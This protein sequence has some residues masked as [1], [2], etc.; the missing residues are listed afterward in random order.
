MAPQ[1]SRLAVGPARSVQPTGAALALLLAAAYAGVAIAGSLVALLS[2][3]QD[4]PV[5]PAA[6]VALAALLM[7]GLRAWPGVLLGAFLAYHYLWFDLAPADLGAA[8]VLAGTATVQAVLG[9][10]W[11]RG[12]FAAPL[13][14]S[15]E[16]DVLRFLFCGGPLACLAA[17]IAGLLASSV[18]GLRPQVDAFSWLLAWW[19]GNSIGVLLFAPLVLIAFRDTVPAARQWGSR[20]ALPLLITAGLLAA[21]NIALDRIEEAEARELTDQRKV[22]AYHAGVIHLPQA[23]SSLRSVER[24]F[25]A[26]DRVSLAQFTIFTAAMRRAP[27]LLA[28]QWLPH[29]TA[30]QREDFETRGYRGSGIGFPI[31][32]YDGAGEPIPAMPRARYFPAYL[33]S[34][35]AGNEMAV[36]FDFASLPSHRAAMDLARD[37]ATL[38]AAQAVPLLQS[39]RPGF[40]VFVPVYAWGFDA[41]AAD[42]AQRRAALA[43]FVLGAF[44]V[45]GLLAPMAA[46][47]AARQLELLIVDV[48]P[49]YAAQPVLGTLPAESAAWH[50][51]VAFAGRTLRLYLQP[52]VAHWTPG[53]SVPL[54]EFHIFSVVAAFLVALSALGAA[55]RVA[56]TSAEVELRTGQLRASEENL[57]VT[58]NCIGDAVLVTDTQGRITRMNPVAEALTGWPLADA[59]QRAVA[60]VFRIVHEVTGEPAEVPVARVL[61]TG[62]IQGLANHTVLIARDGSRRA[63]ADSAAPIFGPRGGL[64]GVVLVFRDVEEERRAERALQ[65][66]ERRYREFIESSPHGVFVQCEGRFAFLNRKA[67]EMLG[68]RGEADL[69]G[70]PVLSYLHPDSHDAGRARIRSLNEES[71]AVP[72]LAERWLRVDGCEFYAEV[73]AVP[74]VHEGRPGALVLVQDI[75]ERMTAEIE[76]DRFFHLSVD[77]LCI[78]DGAGRF[79]R[80]NRAFTEVLG[81]SEQEAGQ[82]TC[83]ELMS[84]DDL[85]QGIDQGTRLPGDGDVLKNYELRMRCKD[86]GYR[87]VCWNIASHDGQL[88]FAG[89]DITEQQAF[90]DQLSEARAAADQAN[91]AKSAF[92]AAMSHEIR[93]PMNGVI[94]TVDVLSHSNLSNHQADL[95]KTVRDSAGVLLRIIDDILDFSKIEAGRLEL[96][97]EPVALAE[98]VETLCTSLVPVAARDGVELHLFVS[99]ALPR[100]LIGDETRLRQIFYNLIGNAIKFSARQHDRYGR[101]SVRIEAG[102]GAPNKLLCRVQDNGLGMS[103]ETVDNL[104]QVFS[105]AEVSTT[106]R[107]GG[108]GLGLAICKRLV[109]LMDGEIAV[110]SAPG[111]G[112]TFSVTLPLEAA[113]AQPAD[114]APALTGLDCIVVQGR[115]PAIEDVAI[116]LEHAGARVRRVADL[117]AA[118]HVAAGLTAPVV[119]THDIGRGQVLI[120]ALLATFHKSPDVRFV[121][122]ARGRRRR[123]RVRSPNLVLLDGDALRR[124]ALLRAVAV[125]AGR[126]SPEIVQ[127]DADE[128][129]VGSVRT[130]PSV[131]AAREREQLVLVAEDDPI[132]QKV[133]RQQLALLGYAMELAGD[134]AEALQMWREGRYALLITDLHMPRLD[135]YDLA[136]AIRGEEKGTRRMPIVALSANALHGEEF[137]AYARGIDA[138]VTKPASLKTL[139][140]V[141]ERWVDEVAQDAADDFAPA[142]APGGTAHGDAGA[143]AVFEVGRLQALVGDDP[144]TVREFLD[145]YWTQARILAQDLRNAA[146][147]GG[148][149]VVASLAHRLKS[150][151][152]AVGAMRFAEVCN[153][154]EAAAR[155][156]EPS[157]IEEILAAFTSAQQELAGSF[158][159]LLGDREG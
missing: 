148:T 30:A 120:D 65:D 50:R 61:A 142:P 140:S 41:G 72:A 135:G 121:L 112:S 136:A 109:E 134:G 101:V 69:I 132:N 10:W 2:P 116:Y 14:L 48:T 71:S 102:P 80:I 157:R 139:R 62:A 92:L 87:W 79:V 33:V 76:R 110:R 35:L 57:E 53:A 107:F 126:A 64:R 89:S 133:I 144:A 153:A 127:K 9:A 123:A 31:T 11:T 13:P 26:N 147:A 137:R 68:A 106:R 105:Q 56:A 1:S 86:G 97:R 44:D 43:G 15:R 128:L 67:L 27:G 47:A 114:Q 131:A 5:W 100:H 22:D 6:G 73:T 23:I 39:A 96:E 124:Q 17:G 85:P 108:T 125:A 95:V 118:A 155:S 78:C 149:D 77:L 38:V 54:R 103:C 34:P 82:L 143:G 42:V 63:I 91:R 151:S 52:A 119:V 88:Y 98:V 7:R 154:L 60:E 93:T 32:E 66:S 156:G 21:G 75:T 159:A 104:F 45:E 16:H 70:Q 25:A 150:S 83:H 8:L 90:L 99:P 117:D 24:F 51:D 81:W 37:S 115:S 145:D 58:L 138:Y 152:R 4:A 28:V 49:G 158:A 130:A 55:G 84:R 12:V 20:V 146:Q 46:A 36:G 59:L 29:V 129:P 40:A 74:Y 3:V 122:I 18:L 94:G 141:L 111:A 113:P 19:A